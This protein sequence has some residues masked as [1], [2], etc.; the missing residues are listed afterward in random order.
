MATHNDEECDLH[1][2]DHARATPS[3]AQDDIRNDTQ[4]AEKKSEG[5]LEERVLAQKQ[6]IVRS[7]LYGS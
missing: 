1:A 3:L 6:P 5:A 7:V 4:T 2:W